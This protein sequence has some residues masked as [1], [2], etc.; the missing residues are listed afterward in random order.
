M[1][2][3]TKVTSAA[4]IVRLFSFLFHFVLVRSFSMMNTPPFAINVKFNVKPGRRQDFLDVMRSNMYQT[5]TSEPNSIQFVLGQNMDDENIYYLHEEYKSQDDHKDPHSK[6]SYYDDCMKFFAT[7][8]LTEPHIADEYKLVH[9]TSPTKIKNIEGVVCLNVELS[10][11]PECRDEFLLVMGNNKKGADQD[12]D[13]CLQFVFG[14][15]IDKPNTFHLHEQYASQ[16]GLDFHNASPH[17]AKFYQF[18]EKAMDT[19]K[20]LLIQKWKVIADS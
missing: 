13:L 3:S 7:E 15:N 4:T 19:T 17:F 2:H 12:E 9:E 14:E 1:M 5:M 8:P 18:A 10:I 11:K 6:T 20:P 16:E